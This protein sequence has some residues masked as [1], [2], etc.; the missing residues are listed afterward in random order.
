MDRELESARSKR[1]EETGIDT[2]ARVR[3]LETMVGDLHAVHKGL[4]P[5]RADGETATSYTAKL[6]EYNSSNHKQIKVLAL[7]R[8]EE[9]QIQPRRPG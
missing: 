7:E 1:I 8:A 4:A 2:N 6:R 5:Q 9:S 3:V